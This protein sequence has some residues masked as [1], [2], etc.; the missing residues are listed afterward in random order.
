M[1]L[2]AV[3]MGAKTSQDRFAACKQLLDYGFANFALI[4]P[5]VQA[6]QVPVRLG[7]A[8]AA[9]VAPATDPRLLIDR[10]QKNTVTTEVTLEEGVTAPVSKG[11]RLGTLTVKA[12]QQVLAQI[13]MV[14]QRP[15]PRLRWGQMLWRV[16]RS[17]AL[18]APK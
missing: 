9:Q 18:S 12:G 13:P 17:M 15:V 3:V 14:A 16:L 7:T 2:I 10:S 11:Q 6:G 5:Q 1:E 8:G 4:E